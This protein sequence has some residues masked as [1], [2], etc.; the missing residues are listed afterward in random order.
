MNGNGI[1]IL[2]NQYFYRGQF[3]MGKKHGVGEY[4]NAELNES[5]Y[6]NWKNGKKWG[7]GIFIFNDGSRFEG[8]W[9]NGKKNGFGKKLKGSTMYYGFYVNDLKNGEFQFK[10]FKNGQ[11]FSVVFKD[12]KRIN[13]KYGKFIKKFKTKGDILNKN[14]F[15]I[16]NVRKKKLKS[17]LPKIDKNKYYEKGSKQNS[18]SSI[19][20][21]QK[22]FY[23]YIKKNN[24]KFDKT[25][26]NSS[27]LEKKESQVYYDDDKS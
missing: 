26:N 17:N 4:Y 11:I 6:G 21:K 20:L 14:I 24:F 25:T 18:P 15:P 9:I 10:N 5:Y 22:I 27:S 16:P 1:E 7:K 2:L 23:N 3:F 13:L 19:C 12:N 8:E